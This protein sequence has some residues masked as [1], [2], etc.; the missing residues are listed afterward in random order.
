MFVHM[1]YFCWGEGVIIIKSARQ[2]ATNWAATGQPN[3]KPNPDQTNYD[4]LLCTRVS[5]T[6]FSINDT[7][8]FIIS[9]TTC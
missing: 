5:E 9:D 3:T 1:R 7:V 6:E 8:F 4:E 2:T